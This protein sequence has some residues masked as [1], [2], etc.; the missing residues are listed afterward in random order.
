MTEL[1]GIFNSSRIGCG[2]GDGLTGEIDRDI[3][4]KT[5][6]TAAV[7]THPTGSD[8]IDFAF[9][10]VIGSPGGVAA[11]I[12]VTDRA[13]EQLDIE[14]VAGRA[15]KG[16]LY[17]RIGTVPDG[18]C[19]HREV[20][21]VIAAPVRVQVIVGSNPVADVDFRHGNEIAAKL[22]VGKN[23]VLGHQD[24]GPAVFYHNGIADAGGNGIGAD[25]NV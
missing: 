13:A 23:R 3:G 1:R 5:G 2:S 6:I 11:R 14:S 25:G 21:A 19:D 9:T 16:A 18:R 12:P 20:L 17:H 10:V 4:I 7:G 15:V 22:P 8:P 24:A